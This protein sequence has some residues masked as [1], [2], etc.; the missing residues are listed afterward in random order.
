MRTYSSPAG[1][2]RRLD[3]R[4]F[5]LRPRRRSHEEAMSDGGG[6]ADA[7][8]HPAGLFEW[9]TS[10]AA[11]PACPCRARRTTFAEAEVGSAGLHG[12]GSLRAPFPEIP[13]GVLHYGAAY[14]AARPKPRSAAPSS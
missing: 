6:T 13:P 14:D 9:A 3:P 12:L 11:E 10:R 1:L 7:G 5:G 8:Q 4:I 2:T